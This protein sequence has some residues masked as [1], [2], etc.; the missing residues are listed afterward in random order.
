M[1]DPKFTPHYWLGRMDLQLEQIDR[2]ADISGNEPM[3]RA[4][5]RL[6]ETVKKLE[7]SLKRYEGPMLLHDLRESFKAH[8]KTLRPETL[9]KIEEGQTVNPAG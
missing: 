8:V 3:N 9:R 2:L 4:V 1:T 6:H 7:E 5:D